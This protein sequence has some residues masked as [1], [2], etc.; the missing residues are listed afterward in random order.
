MGLNLLKVA[1]L[2]S[3]SVLNW[4]VASIPE[5]SSGQAV[6]E[7]WVRLRELGVTL[8]PGPWAG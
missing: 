1:K 4:S 8:P 7:T 5:S 6:M 2:V 3:R